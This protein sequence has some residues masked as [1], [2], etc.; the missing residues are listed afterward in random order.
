VNYHP[1]IRENKLPAVNRVNFSFRSLP[2][3][4]GELP[5]KYSRK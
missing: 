3:A 2:A 5:P 1:R 4:A